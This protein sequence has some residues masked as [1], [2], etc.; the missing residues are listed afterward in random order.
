M[1][2]S[3]EAGK[4]VRAWLKKNRT[5]KKVVRQLAK[6]LPAAMKDIL[7]TDLMDV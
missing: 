7:T 1:V 5:C 4:A 3:A 6:L 2:N